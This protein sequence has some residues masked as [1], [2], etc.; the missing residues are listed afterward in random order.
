MSK[1]DIWHKRFLKESMNI[2]QWS[3]DPSTK[4]GAIIVDDKRRIISTGYNGFPRGIED[5]EERL[6]DRDTKYGLI[7]HA[8]MNAILFCK[9][10]FEGST[11]F[12][13]PMPP[14]IRCAVIIVQAGISHIVTAKIPDYLKDRWGESAAN[15]KAIF[16]EAGISYTEYD[17]DSL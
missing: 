4:C 15:S 16:E 17:L 9:S 13:A 3:K 2:A 14:C 8:E 12:V 7:I 5:T 11:L 6:N 10:P 1:N